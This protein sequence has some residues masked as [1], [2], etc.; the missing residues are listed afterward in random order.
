MGSEPFILKLL[1]LNTTKKDLTF[2]RSSTRIHT[3]YEARLRD[4][5]EIPAFLRQGKQ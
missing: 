2:I 5:L 3:V 4:V 1:F